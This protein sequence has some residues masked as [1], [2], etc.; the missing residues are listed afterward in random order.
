MKI[1]KLVYFMI[2]SLAITGLA[3]AQDQ[4]VLFIAVDDLK[5][6]LSVY[7]D[8]MAITPNIDRLAARGVTFTN[9]QCQ[10]AV[11]GPSRASLLTGMRPDVTEIWDLKTLIRDKNPNIVTL[12]QYFKNQGFEIV[13]IGKIFDPRSVDAG[14]DEVSWSV[15]YLMPDVDDPIY[16]VPE[17]HYQSPENKAKFDEL[18]KE[19]EAKG[20]SGGKLN[21]YVRNGNKPATEALDIADEGYFDGMVAV[22]AI[23]QL[24]KLAA[25]DKR[26]LLCVGFKKPHL[27]F[28]APQKYWDMYKRED[29]PLAKFQ[30]HASGT[31]DLSYHNS[32]E[33]QSYTDIPDAYGKNGLVNEDKQRELIHGYYA[34]ISYIDAQIGKVLDALDAQ[35]L[36]QQTA[37]VL[38]GDHGWHLGDHG[39]WNKHSNFEQATRSPLIFAGSAMAQGEIND[40]PTEFVDIFPTLCDLTGV[41]VPTYLQGASLKPILDGE[42]KQVKPFAVS[43]YPR[44]KNMGYALRND[45]YRYV[46]WYK[47]ADTSSPTNILAKELYDYKKDPLETQNVVA[48]QKALADELQGQLDGFLSNLEAEKKAFKKMLKQTPKVG[49]VAPAAVGSANLVLNAGFENGMEAWRA[50]GKCEVEAVKTEAYAGQASL[51]LTGSK[52]GANQ[53]IDGLKPNTAYEV[54]LVAKTQNKE[55]VVIKLSDYGG[56]DIKEKYKDADYGQITTSF[57]TGAADTSVKITLQKY[58][59]GKGKSWFDEVSIIEKKSKNSIEGP[60]LKTVLKDGS[61][62]TFYIGAT[63]NTAQLNTQVQDILVSQFNYTV[64]ENCAKQSRVHPAPNEWDWEGIDAVLAM[65]QANDLT[66][67]LHGPISPQASKWAKADNRTP[68]ELEKIMTEYLTEEC[69]RFNGHPNVKWM[70]VVN[71][72]VD[73]DGSWFSPKPGVDEWENPWTII[74]ADD[75]KNQTPSYI[76]QAFEIANKYAPDISLVY[77]QHG[78]MEPVMW[79]RV[80]ETIGYLRAKGLRVDGLGWQAHLRSDQPLG[81]DK[82]ELDYLSGLIDWAHANDLDFHVTEIDYKIWD[83]KQTVA[84]LQKQGEAYA[85]IL[86]VLLAKRSTGVVTYNTWGIVDGVGKHADKYMFMFD[87]EGQPKPAYFAICETLQNP[88]PIVKAASKNV[89]FSDGFEKGD[90]EKTW[91]QFGDT[92]PQLKNEGAAE[93]Q[94]C[95]ALSV[96]K[97][98]IKKTLEN[99]KPGTTYTIEAALKSPNGMKSVVKVSDFGGE[100]AVTR[101]KGNGNYQTAV[102]SFTT[103]TKATS[104]ELVINRWNAEGEGLVLIDTVEIYESAN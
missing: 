51:Q 35:N 63:I 92:K 67:R 104:A 64:P 1:T 62:D 13:G 60:A 71:E 97:S 93:G 50:F 102:L 79:E 100:Q 44:A 29:M 53:V 85:N 22:E 82:Q 58:G 69:K 39:M 99:L 77:N 18:R 61:N 28:V 40:S 23:S 65:A 31:I 59:D 95:V 2:L 33:L 98:G 74:G 27:P 7:G 72:T 19:G 57:V 91:G 47:D 17:G 45:R 10:Q 11:C 87:E 12:P 52:G 30:K 32:G 9:N 75:D 68:K 73:R 101:V 26:F 88:Q 14:L 54:S 37:I 8:Q 46:V 49:V 38:W 94:S 96:D 25:G 5:P 16:G 90:F 21:A 41:A 70:D 56:E 36:T 6:L 86:N 24:K 20:L 83:G 4:N 84:A 43:Q 55:T 80:K 48:S 66:V 81:I 42:E 78:S 103:G 3:T 89:V 76:T 34:C 15:P